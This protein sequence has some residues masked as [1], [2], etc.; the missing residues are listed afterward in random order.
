[1]GEVPSNLVEEGFQP[2]VIEVAET[3]ADGELGVED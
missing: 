2:H 3:D 1:M